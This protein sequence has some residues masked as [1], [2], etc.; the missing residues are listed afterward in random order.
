MLMFRNLKS[1]P[2]IPESGTSEAFLYA[3]ATENQLKRSNDSL[4][5]FSVIYL[6][7]NVFLIRSAGAVG[8][9]V[10]NSS[11]ILLNFGFFLLSSLYF[12]LITANISFPSWNCWQQATPVNTGMFCSISNLVVCILN[13]NEDMILRIIYSA[14]FIKH[15]FECY[16]EYLRY[17]LGLLVHLSTG[18]CLIF[19][20]QL[21]AIRLDCSVVFWHNHSRFGEIISGSLELLAI[22]SHSSLCWINLLLYIICC[23]QSSFVFCTNSYRRESAFINKIVRF[24]DHVD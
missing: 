13:F 16:F 1:I 2:L 5:V 24:R 8:L 3:V 9:I 10:A 22:I 14:V 19:L 6:A 12:G 7:L 23:Y 11:S 15:Y 21:L 20:S 17:R 18:F 4:L